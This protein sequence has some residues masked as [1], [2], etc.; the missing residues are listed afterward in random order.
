M[1]GRPGIV[2]RM[3]RRWL[4]ADRLGHHVLDLEAQPALVE[5]EAVFRRRAFRRRKAHPVLCALLHRAAEP[6]D[7]AVIV[8]TGTCGEAL[9][10]PDTGSEASARQ[11]HV[12]ELARGNDA[13]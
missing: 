2:V 8:R 5:S 10:F 12:G 3:I 13:P 7:G 1:P 6:G 11:R 9:R 4:R